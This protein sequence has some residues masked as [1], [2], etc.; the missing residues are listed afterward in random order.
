MEDILIKHENVSDAGVI[1]IPDDIAGEV[2]KA[3][4]VL[5]EPIDEQQ[6]LNYVNGMLLVLSLP[7]S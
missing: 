3:F 1:G 5:K 6:L 2:P 4:V 7:D